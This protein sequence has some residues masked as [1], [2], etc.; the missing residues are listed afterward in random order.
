MLENPETT[1]EDVVDIDPMVSGYNSEASEIFDKDL[2][3]LRELAR[4]SA[5]RAKDTSTKTRA[6]IK[7]ATYSPSPLLNYWKINKY[8]Q[9]FQV[10]KSLMLRTLFNNRCREKKVLGMD[11]PVQL[12]NQTI[13]DIN[14]TIKNLR[15]KNRS[16]AWMPSQVM[17]LFVDMSTTG[18]SAAIEKKW[19]FGNWD[20]CHEYIDIAVLESMAI[21][22]GLESFVPT[23]A[24]HYVTVFIDNR[25]ARKT[26]ESGE[27]RPWQKEIVQEVPSQLNLADELTRSFDETDWTL[28][29]ELFDLINQ[30]W[31]PFSID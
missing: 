1:R 7:K 27:K 24:D 19:A 3:T 31:R 15:E 25:V 8:K 14:W 26:V 9:G 18:W 21:L 20:R 6:P 13:I 29:Q 2:Q 11:M 23:I 16:P 17:A 28:S 4:K 30:R 5:E 10:C 22:L 12:T